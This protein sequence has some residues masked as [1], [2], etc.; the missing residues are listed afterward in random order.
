MSTI[1]EQLATDK[2]LD[3]LFS[4]E[5]ENFFLPPGQIAWEGNENP[6]DIHTFINEPDFLGLRGKIFPLIE[7]ALDNIEQ[8]NIREAMLL[9]GKGSGK[10]TTLQIFM[11]YGAYQL[12]MMKNPQDYY[13]LLPGTPITEL[14]VSTSEKQ[15]REVGFKGIKAMLERSPWFKGRYEPLSTEIRFDKDINLYCGHSGASSWLGYSTVRG[16]MDEVEY[17]RDSNNRSVSKELYR[18]LKGSLN[19]RFPGKYK[20]LCISSPKEEYSYLHTRFNQLK[21]EAE[22]LPLEVSING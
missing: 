13:D 12:L 8:D 6:V 19:T 14:L 20:L 2:M 1:T 18:A 11:L 10:T 16:A 17:M 3:D 9:L 5:L 4:E 22:K 15:A 7:Y 21:K